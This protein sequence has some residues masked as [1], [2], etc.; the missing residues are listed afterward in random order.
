MRKAIFLAILLI[1]FV[2]HC[3]IDHKLPRMD[4]YISKMKGAPG[5]TGDREAIGL[6]VFLVDRAD[7]SSATSDFG[8]SALL[9][10][11]LRRYHK[12]GKVYSS[13]KIMKLIDIKNYNTLIHEY[14]YNKVMSKNTCQWLKARLPELKYL[15]FARMNYHQVKRHRQVSDGSRAAKT[16]PY[17]TTR[18]VRVY[19]SVYDLKA[20]RDVVGSY[21]TKSL[22]RTK[23][24][25][26]G[27][28]GETAYPNAPK[29]TLLLKELFND[30]LNKLYH[31]NTGSSPGSKT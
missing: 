26:P 19:L 4:Y 30:F 9:T 5:N 1:S 28:S 22:S 14:D 7:S 31:K 27:Y 10:K 25:D 15:V 24:Y 16:D 20:C 6:A 29:L 21:I 17:V 12:S 8:L 3:S 13:D 23:N 18:S 11:Q 2:S